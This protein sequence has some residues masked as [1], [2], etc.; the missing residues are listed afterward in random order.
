MLFM[1]TIRISFGKDAA[2]KV[3]FV[4][5]KDHEVVRLP[6][7]SKIIEIGIGLQKLPTIRQLRIVARRIIIFAKHHQIRKFSINFSEFRFAHLN[8]N[9]RDLAELLAVNFEMAN[10]EFIV[11]KTPPAEGWSFVEEII[12]EG[13]DSKEIKEGFKRGQIIGEEVNQCRTLANTPGG[14]MTPKLLALQ[15]KKIVKHKG[16]KVIVLGKRDIEKLHMGGMLG[17]SRGSA[18]DPQFIVLE[19]AGTSN[20]K[21]KPIVLIGKGVTF[22]TGG[23]NLKPSEAVVDMHMDMSG[24]AAVIHAVAL[25]SRLGI[26]KRVVGLI[27]AVENMPSG[28]SYRPGDVLYSMSGRTIEVLNTDAEGRIILADALT[29][30]KRFNPRVVI[31]IAT[32]T[33]AAMVA[34]G[35]KCSALFTDDEKLESEIRAAGED[36]GDYVWPLPLWKEYEDDVKGTF[37]DLVNTGK[38]RYGGAIAAA[39]FLHQFAKDLSCPWAHID[40]AP[41][42]TAMEGECL[43]KG[44]AGTPVRLLIKLLERL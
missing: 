33:G 9:D 1:K 30:A 13:A 35:Q 29:Y 34:L 44:A 27:P 15:A 32:L 25:A 31:D 20:K 17:V 12:V 2:A 21:D 41:R 23:I 26:K 24:G 28:S 37:G 42:M 22:D 39:A 8:I 36:A 3:A 38:S 4:E 19:Y 11:Y 6:D 14:E 18:E 40:M 10:F 5:R 43:S 16:I 7:G